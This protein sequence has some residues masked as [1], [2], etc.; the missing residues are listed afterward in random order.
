[1]T[2]ISDR[3]KITLKTTSKD[4]RLQPEMRLQKGKVQYEAH[5]GL[6]QQTARHLT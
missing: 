4:F 6:A 1:M 2:W 5:T 3:I